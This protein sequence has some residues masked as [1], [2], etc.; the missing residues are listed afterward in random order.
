M[1]TTVIFLLFLA[2]VLS[3]SIAY[4]Q[5]Y[6]KEKSKHQF[7]PFL[8]ILRTLSLFLLLS[9]FINPSIE[10]EVYQNEKPVLSIVTDNSSSIAFFDETKNIL[11]FQEN[12]SDNSVIKD[13]FDIQKFQ[14]GKTLQL[15]DS[16]T[17]SENETNIFEAISATNKLNSSKIA[18]VVLLTDGNQNIGL[19]YEFLNS[20]QPI[21]PIVFGDTTTYADIKISQI[22]A[23]KY[24][25][26]GNQFPVEVLLNYEGNENVTSVFTISSKGKTIFSKN[27][28]F[29][30]QKKSETI[31]TNI[32]STAK[33]IHFYNTSLRI[34]NNEKNTKNN[35]KDFTV[36]VIDEQTNVL[37][38]SSVLHPDLGVLKKAIESNKQRKATISLVT[39]FK[40]Q[41]NDFQL[42][43]L[44]QVTNAFKNILTEITAEKIPYL[45]ISG[46]NTDWNF[47]NAQQL[48]FQKKAINQTE[49]Y[50]A[51]FNTS[52]ATLLQE[53]IGFDDFPPLKDRF[54]EVYFNKE[55]QTLLFQNINGIQTKVPLLAIVDN[56][57]HKFA[58]LFGEGIW[59]WRAASFL[60]NNS[61]EEFDAFVGNLVSFLASNK[62]RNRL[63][64]NAESLYTANSTIN[65]SA[66]YLDKTYKFDP[67]A[68]LEITITNETTKIVSKFPFSL[69]NNAYQVAIENLASGVYNY[70]VT[71]L[72]HNLSKSGQFVISDYNIE[73]QFTR[74]NLEKLEKIATNSGGKVYYKN[75]FDDLL[76]DL[77]KN[78]S[79]YTIQK[80][81]IKEQEIIDWKWVLFV[82]IGFL[83]LEW[84]IRKYI[85]KI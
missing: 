23:N 63:E 71:V 28:S 84:F 14:F 46:V 78:E 85:G 47:V 45:F 26:L 75:Q 80:A 73:E 15:Q 57:S 44:Y 72:G 25:F 68:S 10:N 79:F 76:Q 65:I 22:N 35:T 77:S 11:A 33:G 38:V 53:N 18:P 3:F 16:L 17:F 13:K 21:Y 27:V 34:I 8:L 51:T 42:I 1:Q 61:F 69:L 2:L 66:F 56:E 58:T 40:N 83:T 12:I 43:I 29:S 9:L 50:G 19:D 31:S 60:N 24:S 39:D 59:K 20:K 49:N 48:G 64:V 4:F 67:R 5:Y 30:A 7:T 37:I 36:E 55:Y 32:E 70:T 82:I 54:G 74:A 81:S 41:I 6:Y 52:F 62:K